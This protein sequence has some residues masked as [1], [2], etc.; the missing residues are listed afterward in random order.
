MID[1]LGAGRVLERGVFIDGDVAG[2]VVF[3][4]TM[5]VFRAAFTGVCFVGWTVVH[6]MVVGW[7]AILYSWIAGVVFF[8]GWWLLLFWIKE[9][10]L[11]HNLLIAVWCSL[12][13]GHFSRLV[14][15]QAAPDSVLLRTSGHW[16]AL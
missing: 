1:R 4:V 14:G 12:Q 8:G 15:M 9:S 10:L 2:K 16:D 11:A 3:G 7:G 5:L 6:G 13:F